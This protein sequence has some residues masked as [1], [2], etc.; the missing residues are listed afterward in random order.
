[1]IAKLSKSDREMKN[2]TLIPKLLF[3]DKPL[4]EI[5]KSIIDK[6][7][8][9]I[10][11]DFNYPKLR[12]FDR[13]HL[14]EH[15]TMQQIQKVKNDNEY[16]NV[17]AIGGC[18]A[19]DFGRACAK[20]EGRFT[21]I[22]SI[23]S[24]SC[25]SVNR[26]IVYVNGYHESMITPI[27]SETII[28]FPLLLDGNYKIIH[29]W[30]HSGFGDL[31]ANISATINY[32]FKN[33]KLLNHAKNINDLIYACT[34]YCM[35]ALDWVNSSF[36]RFDEITVKR[37]AC[38]L[39]ESSLD[40]IKR[41]N[42]ELSAS[43]EHDLYY[44][45]MN[46]WKYDR[47]N[48]THGELVSVGTLFSVKIL[49]NEALYQKLKK[50]FLKLG[51]PTNYDELHEINIEKEHIEKALLTFTNKDTFLSNYCNKEIIDDCYRP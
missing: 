3:S 19:L 37:L 49:N 46:L 42:T 30:S 10:A 34:P 47:R 28:S 16:R 48:P 5:I 12:N 8:I 33:N 17:I 18:S 2:K 32:L 11:D 1:M 35:D 50:A 25:I 51:I 38:Y 31:F 9:I 43:G 27:P 44:Q 39:H 23:L 14:V 6:D 22:P 40:V 36:K 26:S 13:K 45:M 29:K 15:S 7:T 21:I 20:K 41:N 24:T 4:D